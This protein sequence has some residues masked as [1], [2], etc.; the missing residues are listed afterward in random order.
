MLILNVAKITKWVYKGK[1]EFS[2]RKI[3]LKLCW[4]ERS[5]L[6]GIDQIWDNY[7]RGLRNAR[8]F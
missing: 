7:R 6:K 2:I 4:T 8:D 5:K 1:P 3:V